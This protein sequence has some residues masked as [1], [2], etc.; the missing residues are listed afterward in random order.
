MGE[1]VASGII[2]RVDP[3]S[4]K[5]VGFTLV[6]FSEMF[7]KKKEVKVPIEFPI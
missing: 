7:A 5:V 2:K 6:G 3:K 1:E 4:K